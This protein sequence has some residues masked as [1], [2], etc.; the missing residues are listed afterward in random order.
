MK[1]TMF[2]LFQLKYNANCK[3]FSAHSGTALKRRTMKTVEKYRIYTL[4]HTHIQSVASTHMWL[5]STTYLITIISR[6]H[7][8]CIFLLCILI[9]GYPILL[10]LLLPFRNTIICLNGKLWENGWEIF[11]VEPKV[12][13]IQNCNLF[14]PFFLD[15]R[16]E[17]AKQIIMAL[18]L[19]LLIFV[20][21]NKTKQF[22]RLTHH[23]HSNFIV[24]RCF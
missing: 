2:C 12:K 21:Q 9:Y 19:L 4:T 20:K 22:V 24:R 16:W 23:L 15:K 11:S 7:F 17:K 14:K 1:H 3:L 18:P 5:D 6:Y 10:L 13:M 8:K